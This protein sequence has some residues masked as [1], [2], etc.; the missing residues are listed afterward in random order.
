[1][2][3]TKFLTKKAGIAVLFAAMVF[4]I[5]SCKKSFTDLEPVNALSTATTFSSAA[6][7]ELAANGV[8]NNAALGTYAGGAIR[9]YAFGAASIEQGEMRG[10]DMVNIAAF[11]QI[12]YQATYDS[13]TGSANSLYMWVNL[14]ALINQANT[15]IA[16]VHQALA[17]GVLT[18]KAAAS[19]EGEARFLRAL[20]HHELLIQYCRPYLDG[21]GSMPGVP[22]RTTAITS[23]A[24]VAAANTVGRGTVAADYTAL[25]ADLDYAE[26]NLPAVSPVGGITRATQGAAIA[27]ETR[28][29]L[30][31]GDYAGVITEGA[32]LGVT[33][34]G[35]YVSPIGGFKLTA[36]PDG[37]FYTGGIASKAS[38]NANN[39]E[40]VFSFASSA[41]ANAGV[42]GSLANM[43]GP[44]ATA[45]FPTQSGRNLVCTSPNL[46][47]APFWVASD[48][49]R[50]LL[51]VQQAIGAPHPAM[52]YFN[53]KY[54]DVTGYSDYTPIIRY[55]EVILNVAEANSRLGTLPTALAMLN[56]VRN[57][58]VAVADQYTPLSFVTSIA[59]TQAILNERRIEFAGE[60]RR[61]ADIHRLAVDP[62]FS[63]GGIPG[64][65]LITQINGN[66]STY[67]IN[68]P[69]QTP[70]FAAIPYSSFH[71]LFAIPVTETSVNPTLA[72]QQNPGY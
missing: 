33:G 17:S 41:T 24:A 62:N 30:H 45:A 5:P 64:K 8:Y 68:G 32:K 11:Y 39:T 4:S 27:L 15:F 43:F 34:T 60:G 37:P 18:A 69:I 61:W 51:Q 23:Q 3:K 50:S 14:Y 25:L 1:M 6:N 16:G 35:P 52:Y 72:A 31:M 44:A 9:G 53:W 58:A 22:Y 38:N 48:T 13:S 65:I 26:A 29:R 59:M 40:S 36:S 54:R 10:E 49:R 21:N 56:A 57:R 42:N 71:F 2:K 66:G 47:N 70:A 19:Y 7:V 46:Y 20:A 63:T 12:T 67:A 28:I 55:A